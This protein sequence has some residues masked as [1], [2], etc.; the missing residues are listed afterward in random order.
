MERSRKLNRNYQRLR[1]ETVDKVEKTIERIKESGR[2]YNSLGELIKDVAVFS[3]VSRSTIRPYRNADAYRIVASFFA[4]LSVDPVNV[5]DEV[6]DEHVLRIK[7]AVLRAEYAELNR[8]QKS[9]NSAVLLEKPE[10]SD[11]DKDITEIYHALTQFLMR[12]HGSIVVNCEAG[13]IVDRFPEKGFER[14]MATGSAIRQFG[15]WLIQHPV[16]GRDSRYFA[17]R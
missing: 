13:Q 3:G 15:R 8:L 16:L 11:G 2:S 7:L 4:S 14:I 5:P 10:I 6:A 17:K 12:S 1:N 9:G